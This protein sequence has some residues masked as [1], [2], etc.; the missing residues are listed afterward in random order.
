[1]PKAGAGLQKPSMTSACK[2]AKP[3]AWAELPAW[4][5]KGSMNLNISSC[6]TGAVMRSTA[7]LVVIAA[8]AELP[9]VAQS[10]SGNPAP[11]RPWM[12]LQLSPDERAD[13]VVK[14]M[15]LAEKIA[16]LHGTGMKDLSPIS[17]LAAHSNGG[18]GCVVG[19][20]LLGIPGIQMSDAAYGVRS[21][22][23]NGRY[24][25][26]LP[27]TLAASASWDPEAAYQYGA[28]IGREL[29]GQGFSRSLGGGVNLT[30]EPRHGRNFE[31]LG[32]DP[33]LAGT[34]VGQVIKGTQDQHV[35][36]D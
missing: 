6:W 15:T 32:E 26:A 21:S 9:V 18:A 1:M 19:I 36:G 30:R 17:P 23:Q 11:E 14:E 35:L 28:L 22:G 33:I 5:K 25:T 29:R 8:G 13:L 31:Y 4:I 16:L 3:G 24:S 27:C 10:A 20:P 34:L 7:I 2:K 12:N